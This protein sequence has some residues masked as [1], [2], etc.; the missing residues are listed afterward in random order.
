MG[1]IIISTNASL[2]GVV[3]DPDGQEG[4]R[5]GGWFNQFGG[6]DLDAWFTISF[7]EAL[8]AEALL[9][10]RRSDEWFA[11]RWLSRSGDFADRLNGLPKYVVS[12]TVDEPRWSNAT[13]LGGDVVDQVS[14][15]KDALDGEILVYASYQLGRTLIEH[16]L[17]DE[18]RLSVFPVVLGAGERLFGETG[19][20]KGLRLV[21]ARTI[22]DNLV[23]LTYRVGRDV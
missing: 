3:Q 19:D 11:A 6:K 18:L 20:Q 4:F 21:Q 2:D 23:H 9:L 14:K 7:E 12:S 17:V 5:L 1:K 13:V 22:G 16:D 8:G 15:L 10:G